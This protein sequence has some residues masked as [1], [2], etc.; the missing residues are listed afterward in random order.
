MNLSINVKTVCFVSIVEVEKQVRTD[1]IS[2]QETS[3]YVLIA[4]RK[5]RISNIVP[6]VSNSGLINLA[7]IRWSLIKPRKISL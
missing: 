1:L 7:R 3:S 4:I 6:F 5:E 2:G